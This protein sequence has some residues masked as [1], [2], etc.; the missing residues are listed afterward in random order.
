VRKGIEGDISAR[1]ELERLIEMSESEVG[2][3]WYAQCHYTLYD[4]LKEQKLYVNKPTG[5][6]ELAIDKCFKIGE[7]II[8]NNGDSYGRVLFFSREKL[9]EL[10]EL[11]ERVLREDV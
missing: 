6:S 9:E 3:K 2:S 7:K 11:I 8:L 4:E 5:Y 1:L 10:G